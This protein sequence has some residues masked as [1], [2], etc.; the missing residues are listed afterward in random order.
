M[1]CKKR[2]FWEL[3]LQALPHAYPD[4]K[5]FITALEQRHYSMLEDV[6]LSTKDGLAMQV[7]ARVRD[8]WFCKVT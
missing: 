5:S 1:P 8:Y 6:D 2:K 3:Q 7:L 4:V